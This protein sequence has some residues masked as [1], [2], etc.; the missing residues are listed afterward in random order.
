VSY[1]LCLGVARHIS[2]PQFIATAKIESF[3][4]FNARAAPYVLSQI[5][6][7]VLTPP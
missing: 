5:P 4:R 3:P 2:E 6:H 1:F 7:K